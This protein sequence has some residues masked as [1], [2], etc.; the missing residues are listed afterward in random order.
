MFSK[1]GA[2]PHTISRG[3]YI[4]EMLWK[5]LNLGH[6]SPDEGGCGVVVYTEVSVQC[7][8][9]AGDHTLHSGHCDTSICHSITT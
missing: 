6:V 7:D 1:H 5:T 9:M 8:T 2:P 4:T 3:Q